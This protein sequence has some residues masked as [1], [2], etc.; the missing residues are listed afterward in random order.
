ML[1]HF[2]WL[3]TTS[4]LCL[5]QNRKLLRILPLLYISIYGRVLIPHVL[6]IM[7][8]HTNICIDNVLE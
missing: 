3:Q 2:D 7:Y 8:V 4:F 6:Y 5:R 1:L